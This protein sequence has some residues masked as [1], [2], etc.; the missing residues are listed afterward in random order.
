MRCGLGRQ[1]I[2]SVTSRWRPASGSGPIP[3][4]RSAPR[5][6]RSPPRYAAVLPRSSRR[7]FF[8]G[9]R[10]FQRER[11]YQRLLHNE[12]AYQL[13]RRLQFAGLDAMVLPVRVTEA[14]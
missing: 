1:P 5:R 8:A 2:S 4:W 6:S 13:Q 10:I 7:W 14:A 9:K 12:T 11:W 3:G